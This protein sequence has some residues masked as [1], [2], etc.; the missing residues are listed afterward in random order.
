MFVHTYL[1]FP[2]LF[3]IVTS[4]CTDG[5][6]RLINGLVPNEGRVEVCN[7]NSWGT[8]CDDYWD[9]P[10]AAAVCAQLGYPTQGIR[11]FHFKLIPW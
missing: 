6:V 3:Y 4:P 11:C 9:A 5:D 1:Y 8:V 7:N 10:D 2:C